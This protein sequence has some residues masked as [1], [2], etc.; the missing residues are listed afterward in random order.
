MGARRVLLLGASGFLGRA[1]GDAL[2][3]DPRV[4]AVVRVGS[5]VSPGAPAGW[6]RHDLLST[7]PG[8]L[9]ALLRD[10]RPDVVV[11]CVG[12]LAGSE[13]AMVAANVVVPARLLDAVP[14]GAPGARLARHRLRRRV[15]RRPP[16]HARRRGRPDSAGRQLRDHQARDD[17]AG[18]RRGDRGADRRRGAARVQSHRP[19]PADREPPRPRRRRPARGARRGRRTSSGSGRWAPIATSSTSGTSRPRSAP[20]RS[21][22]PRGRRC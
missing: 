6:V 15:R 2:D 8:D 17:A 19:R 20:W 21:P 14:V 4:A 10:T 3:A 13:E 12:K 9:V 22:A 11:D 5:R 16:G 1:V 7:S 18:P